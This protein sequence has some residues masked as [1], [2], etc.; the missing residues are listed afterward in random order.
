MVS[1][2]SASGQCRDLL[3][4]KHLLEKVIQSRHSGGR[5]ETKN[6]H[7]IFLDEAYTKA[8]DGD[9]IIVV[10]SWAVPQGSWSIRAKSFP[11]LYKPPLLDRIDSMLKSHDVFAILA[12]AKL[13]PTL[14]KSGEV[15]GTDDIPRMARTDN[16]W[17]QCVTFS[18]MRLVL[19]FALAK[20]E[21]G[22]VDIYSDPKNLTAAHALALETLLRTT[23]VDMI[24]RETVASGLGFLRKFKIRHFNAVRKPRI[25]EKP[26]KLQ[27][28]TWVSHK[29]C[30]H[31]AAVIQSGG[32]SRI[33]PHDI[34]EVVK[35]SLRQFE[36]H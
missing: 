26:T 16:A 15:D 10:A 12:W 20:R 23:V 3:T 5:K 17:S 4:C 28:G 22:T 35:S 8:S 1:P 32:L 33:I 36:P 34:S 11:D 25:G 30:E 9:H 2:F 27:V 14:Y 19:E 13:P 29:V 7:Y 31:S 6:M 18:V 21:L 24:R